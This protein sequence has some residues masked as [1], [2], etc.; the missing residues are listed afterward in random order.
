MNGRVCAWTKAKR[1]LVALLDSGF[2]VLL[3]FA[4][5]GAAPAL[6]DARVSP[7]VFA[8]CR[9]L[10]VAESVTVEIIKYSNSATIEAHLAMPAEDP[11]QCHFSIAFARQRDLGRDPICEVYDLNMNARESLGV[12]EIGVCFE[13]LQAESG[14]FYYAGYLLQKRQSGEMGEIRLQCDFPLETGW[15]TLKPMKLPLPLPLVSIDTP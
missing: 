3:A 8:R 12:A 4:I 6:A 13:R 9:S 14:F 11:D 7:G 5:L 15:L 10:D 1:N 2:G